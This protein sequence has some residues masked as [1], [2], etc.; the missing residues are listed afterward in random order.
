M[1]PRS[2]WVYIISNRSRT[3]YTGVTSD[4]V[5]RIGEHRE[6]KIQG[7]TATYKI[8]RLVYFE[9]FN[10]PISAIEAEKRIKG[11]RRVR[12]IELIETNNP[13]WVDL[14]ESWFESSS[15]QDDI[16]QP[17]VQADPSLWLRITVWAAF[18]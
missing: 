14:A 17:N 4:L 11:W 10:N 2:Y 16:S 15:L 9:E 3:I 6:G 18:P 12:K 13:Q 8:D 7:F 1:K 5:R